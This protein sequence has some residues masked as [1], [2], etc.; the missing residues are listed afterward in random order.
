MTFRFAVPRQVWFGMFGVALL[1]ALG[2]TALKSGPLAPIRVTVVQ[3]SRGEV[4]PGMFGI[5]T[6][7]AQRAYVVG[8]T[9]AGRVKRVLVDVGDAVKAGQLLAEMEPVDLDARVA[10]ADAAMARAHS[11]VTTAEAQVRDAISRQKLATSEVRRFVDLGDKGFISASGVDGKRQQQE[12][13]DAQ[14]ASAQ[15]TLASA[16][17]DIVRLEAERAGARQQRVNVRLLAPVDGM[18]TARDAEP[19]STVVAGQAVLKLADPASLRVR[20][21]LDQGRS[22][23]LRMG[24]PAQVVL[25]ARPDET[26]AGKVSRIDPVSDSVTEERIADV[27]FDVLPQCVSIGDMA[28]VTLQLPVLKDVLLVLN[29]ALRQRANRSGVWLRADGRLRFVAVK[30]GARGLD[31]RVQV[32]E[33]LKAGDE[34]VL[35]SE[36]DLDDGSRIEVVDTLPA[37]SVKA[38]GGM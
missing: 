24:L 7:A 2:W 27:A 35:Y 8:P 23:G 13:A 11:A 28:E 21:R 3:V 38:A 1:A 37:A 12:S 5:G 20:T 25:R 22:V 32:L 9:A 33:G 15:S 36:R 30:A 19:G 16:R 29:A 14:V 17:Q 6:V 26:L 31:G 34:V 18:V 4:A 10:A